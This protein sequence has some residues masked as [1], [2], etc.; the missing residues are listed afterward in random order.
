MENVKLKQENAEL[1]GRMKSLKRQSDADRYALE[2][3]ESAAEQ[4]RQR[5]ERVEAIAQQERERREQVERELQMQREQLE[6]EI[7]VHKEE[8]GKLL[9]Q[10]AS[11]Q[12]QLLASER[13]TSEVGIG[14][15]A[16]QKESVCS[17]SPIARCLDY[18]NL[19]ELNRSKDNQSFAAESAGSVSGIMLPF[20]TRQRSSVP[21]HTRSVPRLPSSA[22]QGPCGSPGSP[23]LPAP[24]FAAPAAAFAA[25]A[26]AAA[27]S[28]A[29]ERPP[30]EEPARGTVAAKVTLWKSKIQSSKQR[31]ASCSAFEAAASGSRRENRSSRGGGE[32]IQACSSSPGPDS[33]CGTDLQMARPPALQTLDMSMDQESEVF[34]GMSPMAMSKPQ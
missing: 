27:A 5:A 25:P 20:E 29:T 24:Q 33:R 17:S 26:A 28:T 11:L 7:R 1:S 31:S 14:Q 6:R 30:T 23:P 22:V 8:Q 9:A 12:E 3:L 32:R 15:Q 34:M 4:E 10:A 13:R 16:A 19:E 21:M 18:A 2:T